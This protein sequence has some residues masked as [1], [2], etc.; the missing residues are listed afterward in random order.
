[1][2]KK[3]CKNYNLE[4]VESELFS[5]YFNKLKSEIPDDDDEKTSL[6]KIIIELDKDPVQKKFSFFNRWCIFKKI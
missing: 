3:K 4:L 2:Q 1:M 6:H 5:E